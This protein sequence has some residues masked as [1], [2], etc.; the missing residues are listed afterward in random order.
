[1]QAVFFENGALPPEISTLLQTA[2]ET[3]PASALHA[4]HILKTLSRTWMAA[5]NNGCIAASSLLTPGGYPLEFTFRSGSGNLCYTADP[6]LPQA[7]VAEKW[8]LI[9]ALDGKLDTRIH[10]LL[11]LLAAQPAQHFG[12]WLGVR[13]Q[14][15]AHRFKVYQEVGPQ[16]SPLILQHLRCAV[17]GL[18]DAE[19][20]SP[21]LLGVMPGTGG[22]T[23]YYCKVER[24][25]PAALHRLYAAADRGRLLPCVIDFLAYLAAEPQEKLLERLRIGISYSVAPERP[26]RITLYAHACQ[27]FGGNRQARLRWLG[28]VRQIGGEAALYERLTRAFE[29]DEPPD[30]LH[31]LAGIGITETGRIECSLGL[32]P[33][34]PNAGKTVSHA[35]PA[36]HCAPSRLRKPEEVQG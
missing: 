20:I 28:L 19:E 4:G 36:L 15:G 18:A 2:A 3:C 30:I 11:P 31:G 10:P 23:E 35:V 13:H 26:P 32:R 9:R 14:R 5:R 7:S 8:R 1:M 17:P 22:A 12:C 29:E 25:G 21:R 24:P 6:G 33:F 16:T 27:L 34:I